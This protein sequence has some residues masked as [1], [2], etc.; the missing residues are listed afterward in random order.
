MKESWALVAGIL[1]G[2]LP[3]VVD[4]FVEKAGRSF[5]PGPHVL[6]T[7]AMLC[8]AL[9]GAIVLL[10]SGLR[11]TAMARPVALACAAI[12]AT[13]CATM[14]LDLPW[15]GRREA[16]RRVAERAG[17]LV[18]AIKAYE[19]D[20]GAPPQALQDL[21]PRYMARIPHTGHRTYPQFDYRAFRAPISRSGNWP[22]LRRGA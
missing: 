2:L 15:K 19:Q 17:P 18:Q 3:S 9:A 16:F 6:P 4:F 7:M 13:S 8:A 11:R 12:M 5:L 22:C 10:S 21:V 1:A 20:E 14:S